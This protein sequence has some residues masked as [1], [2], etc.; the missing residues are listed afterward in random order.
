MLD[1]RLYFLDNCFQYIKITNNYL[2]LRVEFK[3]QNDLSLLTI[4]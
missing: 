2:S 4:G 3:N 1:D